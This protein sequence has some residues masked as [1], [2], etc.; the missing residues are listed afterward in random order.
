MGV[1]SV[2]KWRFA[3]PIFDAQFGR[4]VARMGVLYAA[5]ADLGMRGC[6]LIHS[7]PFM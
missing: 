2:K 6:E 4:D 3:G 1:H 5:D 7:V